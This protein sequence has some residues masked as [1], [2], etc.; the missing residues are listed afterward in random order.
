M[1]ILLSGST[2]LIGQALDRKLRS[3]LPYAKVYTIGRQTQHNINCDLGQREQLESLSPIKI[4]IFLHCAGVT[5]EEISRNEEQAIARADKDTQILLKKAANQASLLVYIS[6]AHIYGDFSGEITEQSPEAPKNSYAKCHQ[7]TEQAFK[8]YGQKHHIPVLILRPCAVYGQLD[9][10]TQFN[11]W[12]LIPF[13]FPKALVDVQVIELQSDGKQL[14]NFVSAEHIANL[15]TEAI[16]NKKSQPPQ[17][18]INVVGYDNISVMDFAKKCKQFY[19]ATSGATSLIKVK[20][21]VGSAKDTE[22]FIYSSLYKQS[23]LSKTYRTSLQ[24]H[25][26]NLT[27]SLLN[28]KETMSV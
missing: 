26:E 22:T 25:I 11:R 14:R 21:S 7:L 19:E 27:T 18:A 17:T 5:N 16:S 10:L 4:D 15:I 6:S 24:Q 8:A 3:A 1:K 20:S 13:A 9:N 12:S 28:Q 23:H 2:G